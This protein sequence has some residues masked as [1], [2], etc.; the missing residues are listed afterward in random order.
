MNPNIESSW[1]AVLM[2][3][4][5]AEYFFKLKEF[6]ISERRK[7]LIFPKGADIFAAFN[8]TPFDKVK[9]VIIG[10]DPYHNP[11]Q[12]NGLCF[13]VPSGIEIPPSLA[14]IYKELNSDLRLKIP[15]HGD[16]Q[17]WADQGVLLL[18]ATLTVRAH[19]AGSHQNM[20]WELFTDAAIKSLAEQ[21]NNIVFFLWGNYAK[22][23]CELIDAHKHLLLTAVHPSP[24]SAYRGFF[25]CKHFSKANKY[26]IDNNI[27]PI[28]WNLD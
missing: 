14:N 28:N 10:Q 21:K 1:K 8:N 5:K 25:G 17:K 3:Q 18:N 26:L 16:L 4:F 6:L 9:A 19:Q 13:S 12:A 22:K 7:N 15:A 23:K 2:P 11:G 20:G 27:E 24:L